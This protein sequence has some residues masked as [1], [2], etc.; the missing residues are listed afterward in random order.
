MEVNFI[1]IFSKVFDDKEPKDE[2]PES[3]SNQEKGCI[4]LSWVYLHH[5]YIIPVPFK[6]VRIL[7]IRIKNWGNRF[8]IKDNMMKLCCHKIA[9]SHLPI[10][11]FIQKS[12][13]FDNFGKKY[14]NSEIKHHEKEEILK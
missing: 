13:I 14:V 3:E 7:A 1:T 12:F 9:K 8:N 11:I 6:W 10:P 2:V 5:A 4:D